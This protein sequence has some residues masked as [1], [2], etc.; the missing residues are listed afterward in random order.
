MSALEVAARSESTFIGVFRTP[1]MKSKAM[2]CMMVLIGQRLCF[3]KKKC[4]FFL[5]NFSSV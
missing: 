2:S 4:V 5:V 1:F 3:G